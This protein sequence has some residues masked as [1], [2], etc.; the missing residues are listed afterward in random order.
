MEPGLA[1]AGQRWLAPA[2]GHRDQGKPSHRTP[3]WVTANPGCG[4]ASTRHALHPCTPQTAATPPHIQNTPQPRK[5]Q[6][7]EV[8]GSGEMTPSPRP[9]EGWGNPGQ[10][11]PGATLALSDL[12]ADLSTWP[13]RSWTLTAWTVSRPWTWRLTPA[14]T[15]PSCPSPCR[16][17]ARQ[18]TALCFSSA[19]KWG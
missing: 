18:A 3:Q 11:L 13:R 1:P 12:T 14:P 5:R 4:K 7:T 6:G 19:K 8:Q 9:L 17:R 15:T 10:K 16:S 2:T